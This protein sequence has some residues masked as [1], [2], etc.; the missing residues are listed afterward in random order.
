MDAP[1]SDETL[2][3]RHEIHD[4]KGIKMHKFVIITRLKDC[5]SSGI[6]PCLQ[7]LDAFIVITGA[8]AGYSI[9]KHD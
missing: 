3:H 5:A 6:M 4:I 8:A 2:R 1:M 7:R 9:L